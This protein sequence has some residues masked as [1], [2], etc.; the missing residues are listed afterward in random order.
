MAGAASLSLPRADSSPE[1]NHR[2][3]SSLFHTHPP[4]IAHPHPHPHFWH[5]QE[6]WR[7][8]AARSSFA[9]DIHHAHVSDRAML[10]VSPPPRRLIF[11]LDTACCLVTP[12]FPSSTFLM[13]PTDS[14]YVFLT[15][16]E[17]KNN[18]WACRFCGKKQTIIKVGKCKPP[19]PGPTPTPNSHLPTHPLPTMPGLRPQRQRP[20]PTGP[21]AG[22]QRPPRRGA[23]PPPPEP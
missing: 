23:R 15:Q 14:C 10:Q 22:A 18:K 2:S 6:A 9:E 3:F 1:R 20:G 8:A 12:P 11:Q 19:S 5:R 16:Q 4:A 21:R 7:R 17:T 13:P